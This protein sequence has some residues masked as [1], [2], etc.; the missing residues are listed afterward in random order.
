MTTVLTCPG[1]SPT[2]AAAINCRTGR[3]TSATGSCRYTWTTSLVVTAVSFRSVTAIWHT[4]SVGHRAGDRRSTSTQVATAY[5][6]PCP[7]G[8][9]GVGSTTLTAD[10]CAS[11]AARYVAG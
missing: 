6:R 2:R 1:A 11:V 9:T 3:A 10:R 7:N 4:P 8:N 5:D